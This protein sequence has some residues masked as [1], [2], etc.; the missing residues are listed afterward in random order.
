MHGV[1]GV[2]PEGDVAV[3]GREERRAH[4]RDDGAFHDDVAH[5]GAARDLRETQSR[6]GH[7]D[8]RARV[9]LEAGYQQ[10]EHQ[11]DDGR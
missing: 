2:H 5:E 11:R 4:G 10:R 1:T 7:G 8:L 9:A 6:G 3:R